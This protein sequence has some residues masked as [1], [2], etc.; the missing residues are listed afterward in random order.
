MISLLLLKGLDKQSAF[1]VSIFIR[2][3]TLWFAVL[4]G[5]MALFSLMRD[6][7]D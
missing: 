1:A 2:L 4:L 5:F 7:N 3:T 6:K